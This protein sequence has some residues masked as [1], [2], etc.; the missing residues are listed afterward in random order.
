MFSMLCV[1]RGVC[2]GCPEETRGSHLIDIVSNG[3]RLSGESH[4]SVTEE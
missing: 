4:G 2:G 3:R 1:E